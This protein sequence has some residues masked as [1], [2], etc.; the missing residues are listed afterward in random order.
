MATIELSIPAPDEVH[1]I[2]IAL[3]ADD[4]VVGFEQRTG[5]LAVFMDAGDW[6]HDR[7]ESLQFRC[8]GLAAGR[9]GIR[10][11]ADRNW[12]EEWEATIRPIRVGRF[13][14]R[15]SWAK[16]LDVGNRPAGGPDD[17]I[18][19]IID[20]KMSFGTAWHESTRLLL[21]S[22]PERVSGGDRV[23]DAGTGTGI[24]AIAALKLGAERAVGFD[25]DVWSLANAPENAGVNGV[26]DR[27]EVRDGTLDVIR[28]SERFDVALANINREALLEMLPGLIKHAPVVGLS[29]LLVGD[30][31]RMVARVDEL[32]LV[33]ID[34]EEE[35]EWWSAWVARP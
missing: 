24:L 23:L 27:F 3:L 34:E 9:I 18:E 12:N 32:G 2:L 1:E 33:V 22:L 11:I 35:G 16:S 31:P 19:L 17:S 25:I 5:V 14:V 6:S 20:P 30:R 28:E 29:G 7:L 21:R 26:H 4:E 15:P 8:R 13:V 10:R